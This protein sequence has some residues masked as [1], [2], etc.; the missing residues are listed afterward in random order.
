MPN[1]LLSGVVNRTYPVAGPAPVTFGADWEAELARRGL[2]QPVLHGDATDDYAFAERYLRGGSAFPPG[3]ASRWFEPAPAHKE[4]SALAD[5]QLQLLIQIAREHA[6]ST[7]FSFIRILRKICADRNMRIV[8]ISKTSGAAEKFVGAVAAQLEQNTAL[9]RDFG[10]FRASDSPWTQGQFTVIRKAAYK[11]PTLQA[12]GRGGQIVSGRYEL[13]V[14]DDAEDYDS[15]RTA[16]RRLATYEWLIRDVVPVVVPGGQMLVIQTP[17]HESDVVGQIRAKLHWPLVNLPAESPIP[18][19][20]PAPG[21]V[22][23]RSLWPSKWP[24]YWT[25][26]AVQQAEQKGQGDDRLAL[27]ARTACPECPVYNPQAGTHDGRGC[28][29]GKRF[30]QVGSVFYRLNYLCDLSALGGDLWRAEWFRTYAREDVQRAGDGGGWLFRGQPLSIFMGIDPAIAE[31][32][33]SQPEAHSKF[34]LMVLGWEPRGGDIVILHYENLRIDYPTQERVAYEQ[35]LAWRPSQLAI[36]DPYGIALRQSLGRKPYNVHNVRAVK[37][38]K[39]KFSRFAEQTPDFEAGRVWLAAEH[40][41]FRHQAL[42]FPRGSHDDLLDAYDL[43]ARLIKQPRILEGHARATTVRGLV[44]HGFLARATREAALT[45]D[46]A[47]PGDWTAGDFLRGRGPWDP[48]GRG[49]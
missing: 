1:A 26:C 31:E 48:D 11:E 40:D 22:H 21:G 12:V 24:I 14:V 25:T 47:I 45:P 44:P 35:V 38:R 20:A 2:L 39:D 30:H 4:L 5:R 36:E 9:V 8:I 37:Q 6:K 46:P 16:E 19:G 29:T 28:L 23:R 3:T 34:A 13:V 33:E 7:L 15:T 27:L 10:A 42:Q 18:A 32:D 49:A 17:Q 43:A 41:V